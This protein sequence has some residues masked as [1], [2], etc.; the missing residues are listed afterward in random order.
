MTPTL[1]PPAG[2]LSMAEAEGV[3]QPLP[4]LSA[5]VTQVGGASAGGG[6]AGEAGDGR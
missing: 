5:E 6:I 4:P 2:L 1:E 3:T